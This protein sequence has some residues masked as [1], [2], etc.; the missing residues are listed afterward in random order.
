MT[1]FLAAGT[2]SAS[3]VFVAVSAAS[4]SPGSVIPQPE[5][6]DVSVSVSSQS[7]T[8]T[9][10]VISPSQGKVVLTSVTYIILPK[11]VTL[12]EVILTKLKQILRPW[13]ECLKSYRIGSLII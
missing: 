7:G 3:A 10:L 11:R 5:T 6:S 13:R 9:D 2:I 8:S 4:Q 1:Y 12:Q